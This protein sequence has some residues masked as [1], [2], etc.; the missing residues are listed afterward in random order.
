[1]T[2]LQRLLNVDLTFI[3]FGHAP[4]RAYLLAATLF[5]VTAHAHVGK[6]RCPS[7]R[8]LDANVPTRP[9]LISRQPQRRTLPF[10]ADEGSSVV[11]SCRCRSAPGDPDRSWQ[12]PDRSPIAGRDR[13]AQFSERLRLARAK[14]DVFNANFK[15]DVFV[16]PFLNVYAGRP[17]T[18]RPH[19][20][21]TVR[22]QGQQLAVCSS[23]IHYRS[24]AR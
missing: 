1:M 7:Q 11:T 8:S 15:F 2:K 3:P 10:L 12:S 23:G 4:H 18:I 17:S 22:R 5:A 24:G 13:D 6:R 21:I 20:L 14:S 9:P 19:A 16:L